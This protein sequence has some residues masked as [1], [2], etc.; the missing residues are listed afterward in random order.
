MNGLNSLAAVGLLSTCLGFAPLAWAGKGNGK[1]KPGGDDG[2]GDPPPPPPVSTPVNYVVTEIDGLGG[3]A[4][5]IFGV[6]ALGQAVGQGN[7][8]SGTRRTFWVDATGGVVTFDDQFSISIP[9]GWFVDSEAQINEAGWVCGKVKEQVTG[10]TELFLADLAVPGSFEF[11]G[12]SPFN[13]QKFFLNGNG[14]IAFLGSTGGTWPRPFVYVRSEQTLFDYEGERYWPTG[15]NDHLELSVVAYSVTDLKS[16]AN[17][18]YWSG[19]ARMTIIDP[20]TGVAQVDD[21]GSGG[22]DYWNQP[23]SYAMSID[24]QGTVYGGFETTVSSSKRN[25]TGDAKAGVIGAALDANWS[26]LDSA[27]PSGSEDLGGREGIVMATCALDANESG[28][29]VGGYD[30]LQV[31]SS[32]LWVK[33][34]VDGLFNVDDAVVGEKADV[35]AFLASTQFRYVTISE[36]NGSGYGLISCFDVYGGAFILTPQLVSAP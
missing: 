34:P 22:G 20:A 11:L 17:Y 31:G 19:S 21:L 15:L 27:L 1:G 5:K 23:I 16:G 28:Q 13:G 29:V 14:D 9:A 8:S 36:P 7:D 25:R 12:E 33:D 26:E 6:N 18:P 35:E 3:G 24:S 10:S 4:T 32:S 30:V 2:G